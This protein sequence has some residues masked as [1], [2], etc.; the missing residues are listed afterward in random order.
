MKKTLIALAVLASAAGAAQAQSAVTIYGKLDLGLEKVTG[1][2]TSL[3]GNH[4]SRLGF[5]GTE[6]LGGGLSAIFQVETRFNADTGAVR[7]YSNVPGGAA[8]ASPLFGGQS[9]VGLTG[10]FGTV[11][12]GRTYNIVDEV[13]SAAIDPFEGD[14]VP[15]LNALTTPRISNTVTYVSP[16]MSGFNASAQVQ[17]SEVSGQK[18]GWGLAG[19]Y[20]NGPIYVGLG[21]QKLTALVPDGVQPNIWGISGSYTF[22][23]AKIALGYDQGDAKIAGVPKAKNWVV[24]GT[25]EIGSGLIKAAYNRTKDGVDGTITGNGLAFE[26][27]QKVSI[28]YQHNLS[29]RTSLYADIARTKYTT[30][31]VDSSNGV[32]VGIT[33]N[34]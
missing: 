7:G 15:G 27:I 16:S 17:L 2:P 18:N 23:P 25:Y 26:K 11:K 20:N 28:G 1:T 34:F 8:V 12:L 31:D 13:S 3:E 19:A 33:H 9:I 14:G 10:G 5:K 6:D 21:Y 29:K 4:Q 22:G 32:G 30:P 24:A